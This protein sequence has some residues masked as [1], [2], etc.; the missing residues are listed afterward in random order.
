MLFS[1]RLWMLPWRRKLLRNLTLPDLA[2]FMKPVHN[3]ETHINTLLGL[4]KATSLTLDYNL[5]W[6]EGGC[7]TGWFPW[8]RSSQIG[9][10]LGFRL[11]VTVVDTVRSFDT[12]KEVGEERHNRIKVW[13]IWR[14]PLPAVLHQMIAVGGG[15]KGQYEGVEWCLGVCV[16]VTLICRTFWRGISLAFLICLLQLQ[17]GAP[18][19]WSARGR[20]G[21]QDSWSP[22]ATHQKT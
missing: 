1:S 16:C 6:L 15:G 9:L 8:R 18:P 7:S 14:V 17:T 10:F 11:W 13:S 5:T 19:G 2:R 3:G 20:A 12:I 21:C 22:I 4:Y